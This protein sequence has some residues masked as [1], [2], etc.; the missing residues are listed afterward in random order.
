MHLR[1]LL[2]Q[3]IGDQGRRL[4][5]RWTAALGADLAEALAYVHAAGMFHGRLN[6]G[7]VLLADDRA[8][9]ADPVMARVLEEI[10]LVT[11]T[12]RSR[13]CRRTCRRNN[14]R[15][16]SSGLQVTCGHWAQLCTRGWRA[17]RRSPES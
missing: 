8:M 16:N 11:G 17:A 5:W 14:S 13:T 12:G 9:L 4:A 3:A 1:S 2:A 15:A 7:N 10:D 6:P